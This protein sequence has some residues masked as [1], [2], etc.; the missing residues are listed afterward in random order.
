MLELQEQYRDL[1]INVIDDVYSG[2]T[3]LACKTNT[4][5]ITG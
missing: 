5:R 1:P 3:K 2:E 4:R